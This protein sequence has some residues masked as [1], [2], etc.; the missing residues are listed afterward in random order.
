MDFLRDVATSTALLG[1]DWLVTRLGRSSIAAS[2]R[3]A[4]DSKHLSLPLTSGLPDTG[5]RQALSGDA[6][7]PR[8]SAADRLRGADRAAASGGS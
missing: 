7:V 4:M 8:G 2:L 5:R 1:A 6:G 3:G